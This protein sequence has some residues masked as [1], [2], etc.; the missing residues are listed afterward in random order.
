MFYPLPLKLKQNLI[1]C[2]QAR[3]EI[4]GMDIWDIKR[5][6]LKVDKAE[7]Y[8]LDVCASKYSYN[9]NF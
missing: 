6:I 9:R 1:S 5:N 4:K 7:A 2:R 3:E 8:N